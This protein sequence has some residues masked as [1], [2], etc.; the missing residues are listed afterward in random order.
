M[1]AL[2]AAF[3][4]TSGT[5]WRVLYTLQ[6]ESGYN[7]LYGMGTMCTLSVI[8]PHIDTP[9]LMAAQSHTQCSVEGAYALLVLAFK[10]GVLGSDVAP[11]LWG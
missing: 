9:Q 5:A 11:P 3:F 6:L 4:F 2:L 10:T 1:A 8:S 7:S